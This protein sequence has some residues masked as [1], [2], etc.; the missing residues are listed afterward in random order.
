MPIPDRF[1]PRIWLRN[2]IVRVNRWL[3]KLTPA[4]RAEL[5]RMWKE[6]EEVS[7]V[8]APSSPGEV[9]APQPGAQSETA[10]APSRQPQQ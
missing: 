6:A 4:E 9:P 7:R 2:I 8:S 1:N 5:A 10:P 3:W